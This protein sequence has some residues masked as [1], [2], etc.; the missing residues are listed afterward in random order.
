MLQD[1]CI[2]P[3]A[4][5]PES[6]LLS[7]YVG[8]PCA[9]LLPF[10]LAISFLSLNARWESLDLAKAVLSQPKRWAAK[11]SQDPWGLRGGTM[12]VSKMR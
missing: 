11:T 6:D 7:P 4:P 1:L 10:P 5:H 3:C 8:T 9:P 12:D 2:V